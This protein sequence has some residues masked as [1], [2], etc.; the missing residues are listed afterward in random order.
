MTKDGP[1]DL[2]GE[3]ANGRDYDELLENTVSLVLSEGLTVRLLKLETLIETKEE[4]ARDKDI[5]ILAILRRTLE[6]QRK[7]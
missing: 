5:A 4:A 6:E 2:L 3:L 1:L 7:K